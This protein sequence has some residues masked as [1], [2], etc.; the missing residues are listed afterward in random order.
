MK[1]VLL[2]LF[3]FASLGSLAQTKVSGVVVDNEGVPVAYAS[4]LVKGTTTG[5]LTNDDGTFTVTVPEGFNI[6]VISYTGLPTKEVEINGQTNL[7]VK[8]EEA[9][10]DLNPVVV[11]ASRKQEKLLEAPAAIDIVSA[12]EIQVK[13]ATNPT[14]Y[15]TDVSGVDI[16]RTG[17]AQ[18]NV[19]LRGF[20][21]IFSG[22]ALT[23][24]DYRIGSVPSLRVNVNQLMPGN[25]LDIDRVEV[26]KGPASALYG[27][28]AANGAI[29][30]MTKSPLDEL[31]DYTTTASI[32][33]GERNTFIGQFRQTAVLKKSKENSPLAIGFRIS[34]QYMEADDWRY[35]DPSE[36]DS[37][38]FGKQTADGR[39]PF[40]SDGTEVSAEDLANGE[41][42]DLVP[43]PRDNSLRNYNA[44]ARLDF[45]FNPNT[46]LVLSGGYSNASGIELTGLGAGQAVNWRYLYT[47]ARFSHKNLFIQGYM[48]SSNAGDTYL[49]RSGNYIVDKSK[50]YV[51][52]IQ[53]SY[54]TGQFR[55]IYGADALLTRPDTEGTINGR[56]EDDDNIDI[57]GVYVQGEY[58]PT[59]WMKFVAAARYD[60][61]TAIKDPFISPRAAMVI[62]PYP[63]HNVRLTF[64]RAFSS[65]TA[66]TNSL[67]ILE[68]ADAFGF[69]AV[70]GIDIGIDG[71]GVGNR[72]GFIFQRTDNGVLQFLSPFYQWPNVDQ[73]HAITLNDAQFNDQ[74]L[75]PVGTIVAAAM[76]QQG[77]PQGLA[78]VIGTEV[79]A[80]QTGSDFVNI[81][82]EIYMLDLEAGE[83]DTENPIDP[84]E[85]QDIEPI[86]NQ[87]TNT[88][89]IGYNGI[90]GKRMVFKGDFYRSDISDFVSPLTLQTPNIFLNRDD[91]VQVIQNNIDNSTAPD[92]EAFLNGIIDNPA[93][94]GNGN[95]SAADELADIVAGIPIGTAEP[96]GV[97]D[98]SLRLTY[99]NFG[100][101]TVYGF[102]LEAIY[103]L[104]EKL[105]LGATYSFV[106]KDEFETEG[107]IIALNAPRHKVNLTSQFDI[108]KIGLNVGLRWR[109]QD[110]FPANSG[111]YVG[112]VP[113]LNHLDV[114]L[115]YTLP[116]SKRTRVSVTVQNVYNYKLREFVGVPTMGRLTL[117]RVSHTFAY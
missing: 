109:W 25:Y 94:G 48:N 6:L 30:F 88:Y 82:N 29:H 116:F 111:V 24:V 9:G 2:L 98:P 44:D 13:V 37:I 27:P 21:N 20:N 34:G 10:L 7:N 95:G 87:T 18:T 71:R 96:E 4:V 86:K 31:N 45:R 40:Y 33:G 112:E 63:G 43:N 115:D 55:F 57:Y 5:A 93:N 90:I 73:G 104:T 70:P 41:T 26:L 101:I 58:E 103:F 53:H 67:D 22:S 113:A 72:D 46:E 14:D 19:V 81:G 50:F 35:A 60:Y 52:Q 64:N 66:L 79:I 91:L 99:G 62:K 117:F 12:K 54:E 110:A 15:I 32:G 74:V 51:G 76:V 78:T 23:L 68:S 17:I 65:P 108:E 106:N 100:N 69:T 38:I 16:M 85:L 97:S 102:D 36:P 39:I 28:N 8:M 59:D 89:E 42:G 80:P 56:N 77:I 114:S 47:Q 1:R 107:Q 105:K 75:E 92:L 83:F 84:N 61:N 3:V 11:S 49:L